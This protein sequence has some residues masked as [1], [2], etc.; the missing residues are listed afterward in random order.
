MCLIVKQTVKTSSGMKNAIVFVVVHLEEAN[1]FFEDFRFGDS[2]RFGSDSNSVDDSNCLRLVCIAVTEQVH[3]MNDLRVDSTVVL[4]LPL[5]DR[6]SKTDAADCLSE[7]R[8]QCERK[9][10]VSLDQIRS[11]LVVIASSLD[12]DDDLGCFALVSSNAIPNS[13]RV[14]SEKTIAVRVV[15]VAVG[16]AIVG[17]VLDVVAVVL[18]GALVAVA[19]VVLPVVGD[20]VVLV[21][22]GVG[23][24][25]LVGDAVGVVLVGDDVGV[26]PVVG[27][28]VVVGDVVGVVLLVL[29]DVVVVDA[30]GVVLLR[31]GL[32][33][34]VGDAAG[35]ALLVVL[36]VAGLRVVG[37]PVVGLPVASGLETSDRCRCFPRMLVHDFHYDDLVHQEEG[38]HDH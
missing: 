16:I 21:G 34:L 6:L 27:A 38:D 22:D 3:P 15:V 4:R 26:L 13:D 30:V 12:L 8:F 33:V 31:G 28:A 23:V 9:F 2:N 14:C 32:V 35:V 11:K 7:C 24:L 25:P 17:A 18:A 1:H 20:G 5:R 10:A 29:C 36:R 19:G 37:L